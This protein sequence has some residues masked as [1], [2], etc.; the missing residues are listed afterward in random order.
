[1]ITFRFQEIVN[2]FENSL[3]LP[4][5]PGRAKGTVS[6]IKNSLLLLACGA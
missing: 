4:E 3:R 6:M 5:D 2:K 1:M